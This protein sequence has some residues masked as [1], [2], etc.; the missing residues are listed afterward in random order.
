M[1]PESSSRLLPLLLLAV[2]A[3]A[4]A[5]SAE[6]PAPSARPEAPAQRVVSLAPS[7]T[8]WLEAIGAGG[9]LVGVSEH[10]RPATTEPAP[11]NVGRIDTPNLELITELRPDLILATT[12]TPATT[13][14]Q[15]RGQGWPVQVHDHESL[16]GVLDS[17]LRLGTATGH[18]HL[19]EQNY[20]HLKFALQIHAEDPDLPRWRTAVML[21]L[22]PAYAAG[23]GSFPY[24]LVAALGLPQITDDL[25]TPWPR[26]GN[27]A[28][29]TLDPQLVIVSSGPGRESE[30][31]LRAQWER[32]RRGPVWSPTE[33]ARHN[34]LLVIGD[35]GLTVPGPDLGVVIGRLQ[36][37]I[38]RLAGEASP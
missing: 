25:D 22:E 21:D 27:E 7:L 31:A 10:C 35:N 24:D 15:M 14:E 34:R 28:I 6:P 1:K 30:A 19:A 32:L 37:G 33:A 11:R 2:G 3:L 29:I 16:Q 5:C 17:V 38:L 23:P 20:Q 4:A 9:Q 26:L 13:I 12:M 18:R 36:E 8:A